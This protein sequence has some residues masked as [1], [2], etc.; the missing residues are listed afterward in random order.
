MLT[1]IFAGSQPTPFVEGISFSVLARQGRRS[2]ALM[3]TDS[4][5]EARTVAWRNAG[6]EVPPPPPPRFSRARA[7]AVMPRSDGVDRTFA[8]FFNFGHAVQPWQP[9]HPRRERAGSIAPKE[10]GIEQSF[11]RFFNFG[12]AVQPWQPPHPRPER[13]AA[14]M[15]KEDGIEARFVA[16]PFAEGWAVQPW[17][18]VANRQNLR[19]SALVG[20]DDADMN[21]E[22]PISTFLPFGWP[23]DAFLPMHP[24]PERAGSIARGDEG[25]YLPLAGFFAMGFEVQ[26]WQPPHPRPERSAAWMRGDEGNEATFV[27]VPSGFIS[28]GYDG[29]FSYPRVRFERSGAVTRQ[30]DDLPTFKRFQ[31]AGWEIQTFARRQKAER[32]SALARWVD[33]IEGPTAKAFAVPAFQEPPLRFRRSAP[34]DRPGDVFGPGAF[35]SIAW[36]SPDLVRR[37]RRGWHGPET[38][39]LEG[40]DLPPPPPFSW[41]DARSDP[42]ARRR[43]YASL[44]EPDHLKPGA[45][46]V[47]LPVLDWWV[48]ETFYRRRYAG[49]ILPWEAGWFMR[50]FVPVFYATTV[51]TRTSAQVKASQASGVT[52]VTAAT[53]RTVVKGEQQGR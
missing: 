30:P 21:D 4:R 41:L 38:F 43:S 34:V 36:E 53:A 39:D 12:H 46:P 28:W 13:V 8:R 44:V 14:M 20:G 32:W 10:D 3:A 52:D 22:P 50:R 35:V 49:A 1:L 17:Q 25:A 31:P 7:A 40:I 24:R 27:F 9:P 47:I 2:S 19:F 37:P 48:P 33:G 15:P 51:V 16:A 5:A 45:V 11:A 18:P 26:A 42:L 23:V 29:P 6:W